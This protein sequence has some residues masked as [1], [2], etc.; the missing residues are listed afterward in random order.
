MPADGTGDPGL[1]DIPGGAEAYESLCARGEQFPEQARRVRP[2]GDATYRHPVRGAQ[3]V[4]IDRLALSGTGQVYADQD[5]RAPFGKYGTETAPVAQ[6]VAAVSRAFEAGGLVWGFSGFSTPGYS[7]AIEAHGMNA[8]LGYLKAAGHGPVL[9]TDGGVSDGVPGLSGV[10]ARRYQI[11]SMGFVPKQGLSSFGPRDH[12]VVKTETYPERERLVGAAPDVLVCVG[13]GD[14]A[15]RECEAALAHGSAVLLLALKDYGPASM[16]RACH[17]G[18]E[19]RSAARQGRLLRCHA[20][21]GIQ[22]AAR[23]AVA[24]GTRFSTP[25]RAMR[26]EALAGLLALHPGF[27][28]LRLSAAYDQ[29]G[30]GVRR[31]KAGGAERARVPVVQVAGGSQCRRGVACFPV[32]PLHGHDGTAQRG[33]RHGG[34]GPLPG[35]EP[36]GPVRGEPGPGEGLLDVTPDGPPALRAAQPV[37]IRQGGHG[38]SGYGTPL[39]IRWLNH[40]AGNGMSVV[41]SRVAVTGAPAPGC[42]PGRAGPRAEPGDQAR[43]RGAR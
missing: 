38:I 19:M 18:D 12:L 36:A 20:M 1:N 8:L 5:I 31:V 27:P 35:A 40:G 23:M 4:A 41:P 33:R 34:P 21:N 22:E 16:A 42:R 24:A 3:R 30:A 13:G 32:G 6:A 43:G 26:L 17:D 10:L 29:P 39:S 7:Y 14:G 37:S 9:V 25:N 28:C 2:E 15:R 11:P